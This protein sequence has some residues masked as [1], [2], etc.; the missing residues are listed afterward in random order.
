[1]V[2]CGKALGYPG[3]YC[4]LRG[5]K[6]KNPTGPAPSGFW[7]W[8]SLGTI[9]TRIP[10]QLFHILYQSLHYTA[11]PSS[12]QMTKRPIRPG[13]PASCLPINGIPDYI[14]LWYTQ[15]WLNPV[16][17]ISISVGPIH[18]MELEGH[19]RPKLWPLK[20]VADGLSKQLHTVRDCRDNFR[21]F[22]TWDHCI[23]DM[24]VPVWSVM[25][26]KG[27]LRVAPTPRLQA[28]A[29]FCNVWFMMTRGYKRV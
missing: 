8:N 27:S 12:N 7:P 14:R 5:S 29:I 15:I 10:P 4:P 13:S 1:M 20:I 23:T 25:F 2:I 11:S 22:Q 6:A 19:K 16:D 9:F 26:L 18:T 28:K 3:E 17:W 24:F 21:Q